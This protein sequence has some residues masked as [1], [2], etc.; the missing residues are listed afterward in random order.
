M[1][2]RPTVKISVLAAVA[3]SLPSCNDVRPAPEAPA[4][5]G[6]LVMLGD[7]T[8]MVAREGS[9][10]RGIADWLAKSESR[11]Q[12]FAF[13]S[14]AFVADSAQLSPKGL[15]RA[16]D[17]GRLLR[18]APDTE[19]VLNDAQSPDESLMAARARVL[20]DFLEERGILPDQVSLVANTTAVQAA[21]EMDNL[22]F[23]LR[24]RDPSANAD[25]AG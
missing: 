23:L 22:P 24:R 17:L 21:R 8:T 3:F 18:A 2:I 19:L 6:E 16:A 11:S 15:G 5:K 14:D 7:G 25:P 13:G 9:L 20:A 1:H 10:N 4:P 12:G